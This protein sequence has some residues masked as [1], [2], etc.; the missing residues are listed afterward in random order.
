MGDLPGKLDRIW[1]TILVDVSPPDLSVL[2]QQDELLHQRLHLGVP[3]FQRRSPTSRCE[4]LSK[5]QAVSKLKEGTEKRRP[6]CWMK[7]SVVET[8]CRGY[9]ETD[10]LATESLKTFLISKIQ[11]WKSEFFLVSSSK[12]C[13][14]K[15]FRWSYFKSNFYDYALL[16]TIWKLFTFWS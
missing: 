9:L 8:V 1:V 4:E 3:Q 2:T 15:K 10:Y 16:W 11:N 6:I 12:S 14:Y 5:C 7:M 13:E